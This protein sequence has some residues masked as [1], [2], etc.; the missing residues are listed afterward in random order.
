MTVLVG[1]KCSDGVVIGADGMITTV[2]GTVPLVQV[3]TGKIEVIDDE[4]IVAGSGAT[5]LTQR[6]AGIARSNWA[7]RLRGMTALD[8]AMTLSGLMVQ[9]F[10]ATGALLNGARGYG[11]G[12]LMAAVVEDRAELIEFSPVDMQPELKSDTLHIV[13]MGSGQYLAEPFMAF[14][15]RVLWNG[16]APTVEDATF[17]VY[18]GLFHAIEVSP[19][20]IGRPISLGVVRREAGAWAARLLEAPELAA[21]RLRTVAMENAM[22][23]LQIGSPLLGAARA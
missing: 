2:N 1:V 6:F 21:V 12:A 9:N 8:C 18:W 4:V 19:G 11:A 13:A 22:R 14:V 17:G 10:K 7:A 15:S 16:E 5:G 20:G 3:N 23:Q